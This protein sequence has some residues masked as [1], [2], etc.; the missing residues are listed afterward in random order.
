MAQGYGAPVP[1]GRVSG[2]PVWQTVAATLAAL[3]LSLLFLS[4]GLWKLIDPISWSERLVQALVPRQLALAGA[5]ADQT[6][7]GKESVTCGRAVCQAVAGDAAQAAI[8]C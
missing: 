4:S 1:V 6:L 2:S 5:L 8:F 3:A 7:A